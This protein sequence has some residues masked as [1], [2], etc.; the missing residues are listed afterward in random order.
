MAPR[1]RIETD[2][3]P[4]S[5]V[6]TTPAQAAP[7]PDVAAASAAPAAQVPKSAVQAPKAKVD[8][9]AEP[10]ESAP[11]AP[12]VTVSAPTATAPKPAASAATARPQ[13]KV[14]PVIETAPAA[15]VEGSFEFVDEAANRRAAAGAAAA[16][17][18]ASAAATKAAVVEDAVQKAKPRISVTGWVRS[19]FPGHVYAFWGA[20]LAIVVA[21][22][23]FAIGLPR[24]LLVAILVFIG[25]A[26][27]QVLDGDP[28]II[29][30]IRDLFSSDRER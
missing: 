27:G 11:A 23:T 14:A 19:T 4:E 6:V 24:M 17:S 12:A 30:T 25:I 20:V 2:G 13:V 15:D 29:R 16:S 7:T 1:M 8:R 21:L 5:E 3:A 26:L 10:V 22:L 28:K 18:A 9:P